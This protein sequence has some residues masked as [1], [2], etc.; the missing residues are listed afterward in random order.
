MQTTIHLSKG[1]LLTLGF[2]LLSLFL[3]EYTFLAKLQLSPLIL[4]IILGMVYGN[5]LHHKTP[6]AWREGILF[7]QAKLLRAGIILYGFRITL[8]QI[9][10]IGLSGLF[11]SVFIVASTMVLGY[12]IGRKL[13]GMDR[14]TT[15]LTTVGSSICG[16]AAVMAAKSV[17]NAKSHQVSVAV[18]TVVIFG[19]IAMFLYPFLNHWLAFDDVLSG[20]YTGATVHEVAQVVAAGNAISEQATQVAVI[21]KLTRVMLLAPVIM[22]MGIFLIWRLQGTQTV[23]Q[24]VVI[25]WFALGFV[26]AVVINSLHILPDSVVSVFNHLDML[27]LAMAMSALGMETNMSKMK[28]LGAQPFILAFCLFIYLIVSGLLLVK[29]FI[30]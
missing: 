14:E 10:G 6:T 24:Q 12:W 19:T 1:I 13:L 2:A 8:Q 16:A 17:V 29:Y 28:D 30:I 7:A 5:T 9:A 11:I 3:S 4:A 18:A 21:V 15:L 22:L 27:L 23:Q 20:L 26:L 25:P